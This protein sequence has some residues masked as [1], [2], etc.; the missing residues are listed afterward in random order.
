MKWSK[1]HINNNN[2]I[3]NNNNNEI[4]NNNDNSN[5]INNNN[6][7]NNKINNSNNNNNNNNSA[8]VTITTYP[9]WF[10][11]SRHVGKNCESLYNFNNHLEVVFL[12]TSN[13]LLHTI[14]S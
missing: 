2:K 12:C 13:H 10:R 3:N 6:N 4:N 5:K 1:S 8:L 11:V 14:Y 9:S 7:N